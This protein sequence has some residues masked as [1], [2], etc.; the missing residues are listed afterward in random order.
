MTFH[1]EFQAEYKQSC[2]EIYKQYHLDIQK[3]KRERVNQE[4]AEY[5]RQ[6]RLR[7]ATEQS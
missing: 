7:E 3:K 6:R 1:F 4:K 5:R 2:E